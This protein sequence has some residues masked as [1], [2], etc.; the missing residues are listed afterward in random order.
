M[1]DPREKGKESYKSRGKANGV[2]W[3]YTIL[4]NIISAL[5]FFTITISFGLY[6]RRAETFTD[7]FLRGFIEL[8]GAVYALSLIL[9]VISRV[10][11]YTILWQYF[12][13]FKKKDMRSF[14][15]L[16]RGINSLGVAWFI[17]LLV[18]A[19]GFSIGALVIIQVVVFH[20][21]A[22]IPLILSYL[23]MN[24]CVYLGVRLFLR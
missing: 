16:N 14:K 20:E 3:V 11:A 6:D 7:L 12:E 9:G 1:P 17:S 5:L 15:D 4:H 22:F 10:L 19:I 8:V 24:V 18:G 21:Q 13:G 2:F 23:I